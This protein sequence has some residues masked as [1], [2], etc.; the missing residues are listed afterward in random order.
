MPETAGGVSALA[1]PTVPNVGA[2]HTPTTLA[3]G[4]GGSHTPTDGG[5]GG[6]AGAKETPSKFSFD[7]GDGSGPTEI[8]FSDG[9]HEGGTGGAGASEFKFADLDAIKET[10]A[11]LYKSLKAELSKATRY[12]KFGL[13]SPEDYRAQAERI[14]RLSGGKG[15]DGLESAVSGMAQELQSFRSGDVTNWA[16][17][18]PEEFGFAATKIADQWAQA[19]PRSYVGHVA[20]AAVHALT[21]KDTYGQSALEAFNAAYAAT[22]DPN[23]KKLLDR[24]AHTFDNIVQ[25]SQYVPDQTAV[26]ER[27]IAQRENAVWNQKVDVETQPLIRGALNKALSQ[28][29]EQ[30]GL[31][32]DPDD[33]G[34]YLK[35]M[36]TAWLDA[37]KGDKKF[38]R[39]LDEAGKAKNIEE[40]KSLIKSNRQAFAAEALKSIYRTRLSKL[41]GN[42]RR[43]AGSKMEAGSGGGQSA[44]TLP[45]TGK[46]DQ[47]TGSPEAD[48][49]FAR[50]KAEDPE[51]LY[52]HEFYVKGKKEKFTY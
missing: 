36:E 1:T 18:S 21:Q 2:T 48:F 43:E 14:E 8:D 46:I 9:E 35:D 40:I 5:A 20:K 4:D 47:R 15:L 33:R 10:H 7:L 29:A 16:K 6:G 41:K 11:D 38:L 26:K 44:G 19:D 50:M 24:V 39:S 42:L 34:S 51:M 17:E 28:A 23:T 49:D 13:K 37:A 32:L 27:Q 3:T 45:W 12:S 30:F 25:N 52:R 31:E 22:T